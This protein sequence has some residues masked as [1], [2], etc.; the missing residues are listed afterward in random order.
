MFRRG[1]E[2]RRTLI[3]EK[4][5]KEKIFKI[6]LTRVGIVVLRTTKGSLNYLAIR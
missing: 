5:V 4:N 2:T 1:R 6:K 3:S